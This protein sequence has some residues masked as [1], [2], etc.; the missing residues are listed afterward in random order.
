MVIS[1]NR[2]LGHTGRRGQAYSFH[3]RERRK[4]LYDPAYELHVTHN[5]GFSG[6]FD[7]GALFPDRNRPITFSTWVKKTPAAANGIIFEAGG[8]GAGIAMWV[9]NTT[10]GIAAGDG[11]GTRGVSATANAVFLGDDLDYRIVASIFP[12]TGE[13][14]VWVRGKPVISS[15]ADAGRLNGQ[16]GGT[17][18]GGVAQV[19]GSVNTRVPAASRVALAGAVITKQV[20]A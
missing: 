17:D 14:C 3:A 10:L 12:Q 18:S 20:K 1:L 8:S 13:V 9:N 4:S 7:T 6:T 16:W 2:T 11:T 5:L 15:V 19:G